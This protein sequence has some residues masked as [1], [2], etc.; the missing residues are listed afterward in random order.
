MFCYKCGFEIQDDAQFCLKCGSIQGSNVNDIAYNNYASSNDFDRQ[1]IQIYISNVLNLECLRAKLN[2]D[3]YLAEKNWSYEYYNNYVERFAISNGY[4]WLAYYDDK[5]YIGAFNDGNYGGAYT[6]E[7]LNREHMT[8]GKGFVRYV[9]GQEVI[10]HR[11]AFYW[12]II[13][14]NS[15]PMIKK[16]AFWWDIGNSKSRA[17]KDFLKV[18]SRFKETA[19][20]IYKE[21]FANKVQPLKDKVDGICEEWKKANELLQSAYDINII[22][23]Q[24][25]NI[26]AIWFIHDFIATSNETLTTALLHCDLDVIKQKLDCII[27]QNRE[28]IINQ[29]IQE[30]Q[31]VQLIEHNQQTLRRL[32]NIERNTDWAAKYSQ[33]AANNAEACA[34]IGLANYIKR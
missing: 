13:D 5:F 15:L 21:N 25:R 6:G 2:D 22:P 8:D 29:A 23:Q 16:S 30:A 11:G 31:N 14:E 12:G 32:A 4:I 28:I 19:P 26:H 20:K 24:F 33:I 1:A 3:Y 10:K 7:F 18:Y 9:W 27:E 17:K 34:W